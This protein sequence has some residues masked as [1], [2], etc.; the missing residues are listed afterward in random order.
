MSQQNNTIVFRCGGR[1][2]FYTFW[3]SDGGSNYLC[4]P[5]KPIFEKVGSGNQGSNYIYGTEY[6]IGHAQKHLFENS[7]LHDHDAPCAVCHTESRGSHMMIPAR[8]TCPSGWTLEYKGYI[9]SEHHGHKGRTQ[10]ICV[11]GKAE[12]TFGS[13][14]NKNGA[15]LYF[16]EGACGS[17]PC[18]P[19]VQ[20]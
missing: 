3:T 10:Y 19:Y 18:P 1:V 16:V 11:D 2:T 4:L 14:V 20:G 13:H 8:N 9:M 17:L 15:L 7:K 5:L 6:E 12:A